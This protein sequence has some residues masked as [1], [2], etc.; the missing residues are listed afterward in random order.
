MRRSFDK[1]E[2]DEDILNIRDGYLNFR[3]RMEDYI[4]T[5]PSH[6]EYLRDNIYGGVDTCL[7]GKSPG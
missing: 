5:L 6:Y 4:K 2:T 3:N 7:E 1:I